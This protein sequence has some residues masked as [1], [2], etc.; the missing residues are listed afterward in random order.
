MKTSI[1]KLIFGIP[2]TLFCIIMGMVLNKLISVG[3]NLD[4][5][6]PEMAIVICLYICLGIGVYYVAKANII[7]D[8]KKSVIKIISVAFILILFNYFNIGYALIRHFNTDLILINYFFNINLLS[9]YSIISTQAHLTIYNAMNQA[10]HLLGLVILCWF[11]G[12][13]EKSYGK[14]AYKAVLYGTIFM[15]LCVITNKGM[16]MSV[17]SFWGVIDMTLH[18]EQYKA[19]FKLPLY[20]IRKK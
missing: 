12:N 6:S 8:I 17:L 4:T 1:K 13:R 3:S 11:I 2:S 7:K 14:R 9:N 16:L 10:M 5:N 18:I 19:M 20:L 15:A